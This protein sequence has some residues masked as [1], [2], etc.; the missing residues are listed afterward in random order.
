M[1]FV[2]RE[3]RAWKTQGVSRTAL[4][5][6]AGGAEGWGGSAVGVL[7]LTLLS[8]RRGLAASPLPAGGGAQLPSPPGRAVHQRGQHALQL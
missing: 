3:Q 7:A 4:P 1:L 6:G 5:T 2:I 8:C